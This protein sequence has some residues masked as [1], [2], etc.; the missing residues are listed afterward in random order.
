MVPTMTSEELTQYRHALALEYIN[1]HCI[2][3][4]DAEYLLKEAYLFADRMI[5][6]YKKAPNPPVKPKMPSNVPRPN[7]TTN[8]YQNRKPI[9]PT[10]KVF[11]GLLGLAFICWSVYCLYLLLVKIYHILF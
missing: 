2:R 11:K 3:I 7:T 10:S 9:Y 4:N 6:A 8:Y 1:A 5:D